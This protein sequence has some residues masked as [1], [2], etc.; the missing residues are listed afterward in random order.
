[1]L[2]VTTCRELDER[3]RA[4]GAGACEGDGAQKTPLEE[5]DRKSKAE[6]SVERFQRPHDVMR[7]IF[8]TYHLRSCIDRRHSRQYGVA[9]ISLRTTPSTSNG[10]VSLSVLMKL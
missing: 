6:R 8:V 2:L 1:M 10:I 5:E 4:G 7:Q 9:S 3:P